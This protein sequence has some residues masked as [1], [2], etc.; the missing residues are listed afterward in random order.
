M[1]DAVVVGAGPAGLYAPQCLVREGLDVVVLE[2]HAEIGAPTHCTGLMSAESIELYK[3]PDDVVLNRP[4]VCLV[5]SPRGSVAALRSG[6]EEIVV[7][8][9]AGFDRALAANAREAGATI[10]TGS[11]VDRIDVQPSFVEVTGT[12][13]VRRARVVVLA[14][15]V[16]YR[17]HRPLGLGTPSVV[18]T[19]QIEVGAQPAD[20]LEIHLGRSVAPEGFV[21]LVPV[22]RGAHDALK[23]GILL[24]GDARAHLLRFLARDDVA[25]RLATTPKEPIRRLLP[26]APAGRTFGHR[27]VAVGDAAGLTKPVTGGGI[28][29]SL[30]SAALA[31]ET[32]IEAFAAGEP[33]AGR[34]SR[35]ESRWRARLA[36]EIRTG[37]WFRH[38]LTRLSDDELDTFV[39][40]CA[41]DDVQAVI[42]Q[43][44]R[45]NWHRSLILALLRQ[46]GI[47][48]TLLRSLLR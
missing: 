4:T 44:A 22:K 38:L 35:Y 15:G 34:L 42:N 20:A 24:R 1:H 18:H 16:T 9:R 29:Y 27:L 39:Q 28:F 12:E 17:F 13:G 47:K 2:E 31:A 25:A 43:T 46:R 30:L 6:P 33:D 21:W 19:A 26:V 32:L 11:R 5:A 23:A 8:D 7:V 14:A 37:E 36:G 10:V 48:S 40:A 45:F 41:S 3:F